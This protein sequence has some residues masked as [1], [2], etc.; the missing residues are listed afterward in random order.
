[1]ELKRDLEP[2]SR[3]ELRRPKT[4]LE[5]PIDAVLVFSAQGPT[6]DRSSRHDV[7]RPVQGRGRD[8][9]LHP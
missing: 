5:E 9:R 2:N 1:M 3:P 6:S 4:P 8:A 7:P